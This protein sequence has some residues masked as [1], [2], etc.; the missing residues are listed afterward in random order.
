MIA[1]DPAE[2]GVVH[3][4]RYAI[5]S[6]IH[7]NREAFAAC[8]A[9]AGRHGYDRAVLLGDIVGYG[10]DPEWCVDQAMALVDD[11]AIA[12]QGNH[13]AAIATPIP[14]M[15][16]AP[17]RAISWT[18]G[19]LNAVQTT[20]LSQLP[21][22]WEASET[23][24]VHASPDRPDR[25]GYVRDVDDAAAA[26]AATP[27]RVVLC[28]HVHRPALYGISPGG[29]VQGWVLN[30]DIAMPLAG[31]HRWLAVLGSVG[32][33]RDGQSGAAYALFDAASSSLTLTRVAYDIERAAGKIRAAGLPSDFAARLFTGF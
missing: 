32:Q 4:M 19:R 20:F 9:D 27:H 28:G 16:E 33:P 12:M 24:F 2:N 11:G 10:A 30:A 22:T 14:T 26:M 17:A 7:A 3:T 29:E 15:R 8:L 5:F 23:L 18:R 31:P 25:W 21:L 1:A 13:D 6:D